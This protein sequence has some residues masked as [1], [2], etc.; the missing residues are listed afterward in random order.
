MA[1]ECLRATIL[2]LFLTLGLSPT[3]IEAGAKQK[4]P[5]RIGNDTLGFHLPLELQGKTI[6]GR[7]P[8]E[9]FEHG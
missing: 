1:A 3:A 4:I 5:L 8:D 2:L 6:Y 7:S 9:H